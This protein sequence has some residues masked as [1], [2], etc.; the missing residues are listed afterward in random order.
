MSSPVL[1]LL[2]KVEQDI[3]LARQRARQIAALLGYD[4]QGQIRVATAVSEI[5]RNALQYASG[6][7]VEFAL[8]PDKRR[9]VVR[10]IDKGKGIPDLQSVLGGLYQS[11]TGLGMGIVGTRRLMDVFDVDTSAKGT[12]VTLGS[13]LPRRAPPIGADTAARIA[14]ELARQR[15]GDA[16]E[17]MQRQNQELLTTLD[18]VT[19]QRFDLEQVNRELEETNRG[20]VALYAEI[21]ERADFL[22][23][24]NEVKTKFLSNMTHEFRTP[25]NSIISL[26]RLLLERYDGDLTGEQEKQIKFIARSAEDLSELVNDLLDLS[27][28]EA[29]KVVVRPSQ[30]TVTNL[31]AALRGMLRPL[32]GRNTSV[33]LVFEEPEGLPALFTDEL[34]V[35]QILRNFISNALKYTESGEVRVSARMDAGNNVVFQVADTGIGI[36][37]AD[38]ERVFEEY[39]QIDSPLQRRSRGTG[40]G[41]PLTRRL[42]GLL[43]G[44]VRLKSELG[45]G[46]TFSAIIPATFEGS[47]S[48]A[49]TVDPVREIDP[50]RLP[51][52]VVED[53]REALFIY[54]KFLGNSRYQVVPARTLEQARRA[55]QTVQPVAVILDVLLENENTWTFIR[56]LRD[57]PKARDAAIIVVTMVDNERQARTLGADDYHVKPITREWLVDTLTRLTLG[58]TSENILLIDDDEVSRYL[59]R[60]LLADTRYGVLEAPSGLDGV[61]RAREARPEAIILDVVMP[62]MDGYT[63]LEE[64]KRDTELRRIPVIVYTS[65]LLTPT[66]RARLSEAVAIVPKESASREAAHASIHHALAAAGLRP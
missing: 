25:L 58:R 34:K 13:T 49:V 60:G 39:T 63:V 1:T 16:Y 47:T 41:L 24:A 27:K 35:S 40:L 64:L 4:H 9:L 21:D 18:Q 46:S 45:M 56:E 5:A 54:E 38:H 50:R 51:V 17:E 43:G 57:H 44:S 59:L 32:I 12:T 42:A 8:N 11:S 36:A 61:E 53:N 10:V 26:T 65:K 22:Q 52:L 31:F 30:F 7:K 15:P 19:A 28:V 3:V 20:V 37:T 6:G 48:I 33:N 2:L 14:E 29:G 62:E 55:L 66:E 23:R